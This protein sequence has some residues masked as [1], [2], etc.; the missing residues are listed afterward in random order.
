MAEE[1]LR[2]AAGFQHLDDQRCQFV[3]IDP[4]DIVIFDPG[5]ALGHGEVEAE[6]L[7]GLG[8]DGNEAVGATTLRGD[9]VELVH[10]H[11]ALDGMAAD[12][13]AGRD[14]G[15]HRGAEDLF[16][17]RRH[18]IVPGRELDPAGLVVGLVETLG[19]LAQH[20]GFE[21]GLARGLDPFGDPRL[22]V[23][24]G[25]DHDRKIGG[26]RHSEIEIGAAADA[27]RRAFDKGGDA[28]RLDA[29]DLGRHQRDHIGSI[30]LRVAGLIGRPQI[31][32]HMLMRQ[33]HAELLA[34]ERAER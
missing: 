25:G 27:A 4:A 29:L 8:V 19:Q 5:A 1:E 12:H 15:A 30:R 23:I 17:E 2:A 26:E 18:A 28:E 9:D 34:G 33:D 20:P 3:V 32:E 14:R 13:G 22:A 6:I 21:L 7:L 31:D 24:A 10:H 11:A 16:L